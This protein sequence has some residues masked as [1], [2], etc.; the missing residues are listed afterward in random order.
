MKHF[1]RSKT[2]TTAA[3]EEDDTCQ[4]TLFITTIIDITTTLTWQRRSFASEMRWLI[5]HNS[6][7]YAVLINLVISFFLIL[8]YLI[9]CCHRCCCCWWE[10]DMHVDVVVI[11]SSKDCDRK[12]RDFWKPQH[13]HSWAPDF[14]TLIVSIDGKIRSTAVKNTNFWKWQKVQRGKQE[15]RWFYYAGFWYLLSLTFIAA[16]KINK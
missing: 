3:K 15:L 16:K 6:D 1:R 2:A 10:S 14:V 4:R 11:K 5:K 9:F 12:R 13:L 7:D 8:F